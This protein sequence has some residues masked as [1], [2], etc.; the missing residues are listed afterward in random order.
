VKFRG[1]GQSGSTHE[2]YATATVERQA[3]R[4]AL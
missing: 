3:T 2:A 4:Q 1:T